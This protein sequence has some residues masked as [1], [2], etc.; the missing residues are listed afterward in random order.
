MK[1][2]TKPVAKAPR[3]SLIFDMRLGDPSALVAELKAKLH[4]LWLVRLA[5]SHNIPGPI[6]KMLFE[7]A[8]S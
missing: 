2:K 7:A 3:A 5:W 1:P 8:H 4:P 6:D